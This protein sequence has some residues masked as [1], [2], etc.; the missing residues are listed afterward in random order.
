MTVTGRVLDP[1]GKPV[2]DAAV[3]V[4]VQSKLSDRPMLAQPRRPMTA[5]QGRCDAMGRFHVE[6]PR[7]SSARH[8]LLLVTALAP[9]YGMSW[10][11]LDPDADPITADLALRT[12]QVIRGRLFGVQGRPARGSRSRSRE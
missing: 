2:P 6:L 1:A 4:V 10:V 11:E 7:T 3:M 12:E 8:D 9:G 5:H